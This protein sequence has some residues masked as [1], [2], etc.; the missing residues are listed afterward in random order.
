M[1]N[2]NPAQPGDWLSRPAIPGATEIID[3]FGG[4][5]FHDAEVLALHLE[6]EGTS[7]IKVYTWNMTH[8]VGSDG[9]YVLD[10]HAVVTFFMREVFDL[11]LDGFAQNV[12]DK[13]AI[14]S[15][16]G[17]IVITLQPTYGMAGFVK[18]VEVWAALTPGRL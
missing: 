6:R 10:K 18:A 8:E 9:A 1:S 17:G 14:E 2:N 7:W 11:E 5:P 13:L 4:W 12:I 3:W 16:E 15:C